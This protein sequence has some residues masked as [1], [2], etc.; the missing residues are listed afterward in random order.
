LKTGL[1]DWVGP[2]L[3]VASSVEEESAFLKNTEALGQVQKI[4]LKRR[5]LMLSKPKYLLSHSSPKFPW[6]SKVHST[7]KKLGSFLLV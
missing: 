7:C 5:F 1:Q 3:S 2:L 4:C 6:A